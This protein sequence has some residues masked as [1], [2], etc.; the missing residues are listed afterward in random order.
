MD[1]QQGINKED[2]E[3]L[4]REGTTGSWKKY[5]LRSVLFILASVACL[6]IALVLVTKN[7]VTKD[8]LKQEI[9]KSINSNVSIGE[10]E[11]SILSYPATITLKDVRLMPKAGSPA[12]DSPVK[13]GEVSLSLELWALL[14]KHIVVTNI[15]IRKAE[16]TTT[17]YE[18]GSTSLQ[19]MFESPDKKKRKRRGEKKVKQ[20]GPK[21]QGGF[22]AYDQEE[23]IAT[24]GGLFIEDANV[25]IILEGMGLRLLCDDVDIELSSLTFDP[26]QLAVSNEAKVK[27]RGHVRIYSEQ[28]IQYA[29]LYVHGVSTAHIFNPASGDAEP[30]VRGE[31]NLSDE[32]WINTQLP[33]ITRSWNHLA[34]L[35]KV[36]IKV[37]KL[38]EQATFGRSKSVSAHHH[39]GKVIIEKPL[40]IWVGDWEL[41]V[42][43]GARL[44]TK[45]DQHKIRAELLASQSASETLKPLVF[46]LVDSLPE[47]IRETV[48]GDLKQDLFRDDRLLVK[49]KSS[50]DFSDPKVRADGKIVDVSKATKE[51]AKEFF[52]QKAGGILDGLLK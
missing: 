19:A 40:S 26:K 43:G 2:P 52:K 14:Q 23:F 10:F 32:S 45:T 49:I 39:Q 30:D 3:G 9:E 33:V 42:L 7:F 17:Y 12:A 5:L 46:T 18:D 25:K 36:G 31:F 29:E 50:G 35:E 4:Q 20:R 6:I 15:T 37:A 24:L 27:I 48:G 16:I 13:I 51:A 8:L 1:R 34:V 38:P 41:A 44:D 47:Q 21:K 22:N 28:A 11:L